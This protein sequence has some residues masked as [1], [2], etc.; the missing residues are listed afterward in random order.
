MEPTVW[1]IDK[2]LIK[3]VEPSETLMH[4]Y[5]KK[6]INALGAM[7]SERDNREWQIAAAYYAIYFS[8]YALCARAG[9][10]SEAHICT[11][12]LMKSGFE[13]FFTFE[14]RQL[15]RDAR[16]LRVEAQY[17]A[18]PNLNTPDTLRI[19]EATAPFHVKCKKVGMELNE[20]TIEK[21]RK[22]IESKVKNNHNPS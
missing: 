16:K 9:I 8:F 1:C 21:I 11:L 3:I 19:L 5:F 6:A 13:A 22:N 18:S 17:Y 4:A 14:D 2:K 15:L 20:A 10:K 7:D 12:A